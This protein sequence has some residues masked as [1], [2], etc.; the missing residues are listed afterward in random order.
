M[1]G[2]IEIGVLDLVLATM[3]I[4]ALGPEKQSPAEEKKPDYTSRVPQY[5]FAETPDERIRWLST[6]RTTGPGTSPH[7][8][9]RRR[10]IPKALSEANDK[11]PGFRKKAGLL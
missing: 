11:K 9:R 1:S 2:L 7:T 10:G 5:T 8:T 4:V 6:P 3:F